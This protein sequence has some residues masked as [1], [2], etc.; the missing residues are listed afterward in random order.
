VPYLPPDVIEETV[1]PQPWGKDLRNLIRIIEEKWRRFYPLVPYHQLATSP[2][3]PANTNTPNGAA[4]ST[5]FDPLYGEAVDP[6]MTTIVQPHLSGTFNAAN[7]EV[8]D[9]PV[10][11]NIKVQP[12]ELDVVEKLY[13]FDKTRQLVLTAPTST[14]DRNG[15]TVQEG[16]TVE[17]DGKIFRVHEVTLDKFWLN[18]NLPLFIVWTCSA[19]RV[20]S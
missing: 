5:L 12:F 16:D 15:I 10:T 20:G 13:G 6:T 19:W 2:T 8:F 3:T 17:W 18:T 7:P 1:L 4:G 14:L 9:D 11:F